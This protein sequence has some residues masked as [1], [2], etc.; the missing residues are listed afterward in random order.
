[1]KVFNKFFYRRLNKFYFNATVIVLIVFLFASCSSS[2]DTSS[3]FIGGDYGEP[4]LTNVPGA[5]YIYQPIPEPSL[6]ESM[7]YGGNDLYASGLFCLNQYSPFMYLH[8]YAGSY[9]FY[10][11]Y[12]SDINYPYDGFST[13][14]Y[15]V[16]YHPTQSGGSSSD[17]ITERFSWND[18]DNVSE[19]IHYLDKISNS[20]T[21]TN[22]NMQATK[23]RKTRF[24]SLSSSEE[25]KASGGSSYIKEARSRNNNSL[26]ASPDAGSSTRSSGSSSATSSKSTITP[27]RSSSSSNGSRSSGPSDSNAVKRTK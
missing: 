15:F 4:A 19:N 27:S 17:F 12:T 11:G 22:K 23:K 7:L 1:M 25:V 8:P 20:Q 21:E 26:F 5:A 6:S 9:S 2:K 14:P 18:N 24:V 16:G 3:A 10:V 13:T